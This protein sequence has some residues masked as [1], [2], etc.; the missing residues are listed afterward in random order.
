[1][2]VVRARKLE[3][4]ARGSVSFTM[5][6]FGVVVAVVVVRF[7][8]PSRHKTQVSLSRAVKCRTGGR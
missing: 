6:V 4:L 3:Y 5:I 2:R 8:S 1:M 7:V